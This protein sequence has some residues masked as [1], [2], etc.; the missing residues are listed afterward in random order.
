[1]STNGAGVARFTDL[2]PGRYGVSVHYSLG[3]I[4]IG[5]ETEVEL[6][7]N[8]RVELHFLLRVR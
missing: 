5:K 4:T 1:M 6:E 7:C 8:E 2:C 3:D